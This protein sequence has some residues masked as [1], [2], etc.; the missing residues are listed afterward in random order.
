ML[1]GLFEHMGMPCCY[2]IKVMDVLGFIEIPQQLI[3]KR[4]TRDARDVLPTHLQVYQRDQ[5]GN[6]SMT[7]RHTT[8]YVHAMELVPKKAFA[9]L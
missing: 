5:A 4:W 6:R 1:I 8:L 3:M 9:P 7:H 2:M